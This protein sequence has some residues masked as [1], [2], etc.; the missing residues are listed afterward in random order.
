MPTLP[1]AQSFGPRPI[2]RPS[3]NV[4]PI[5]NDQVQLVI[6]WRTRPRWLRSRQPNFSRNVHRFVA[7]KAM[8]DAVREIRGGMG[9]K[10][11]VA[12][13]ALAAVAGIAATAEEAAAQTP[14]ERAAF[15]AA[16]A[17]GT[18]EAF[19]VF[20]IL[21]PNSALAARAFEE[22]NALISTP[23]Q[24]YVPAPLDP[25]QRLPELNL[26]IGDPPTTTIY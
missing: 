5:R 9:K 13:S 10:L 25:T 4:V 11:L 18:V 20:L 1:T 16:L 12:L 17:E 26:T 19:Q 14:E 22:L 23:Q 15:D 7:Q 8:S 3:R 2:P 21:H 24:P 6:Q